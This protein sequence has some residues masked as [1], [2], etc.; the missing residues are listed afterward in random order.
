MRQCKDILRY[1]QDYGSITP[2]EAIEQLGCYRLSGR[3]HDLRASGV[4]IK[5][6]PETRKK[7]YGKDVTYA[8]YSIVKE[9]QPC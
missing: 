3:I 6:T 1:M 4:P 7:R 2:M 9:G 8:R 5:T